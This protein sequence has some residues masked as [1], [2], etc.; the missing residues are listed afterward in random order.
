[1]SR[2]ADNTGND[3]DLSLNPD[4]DTI[5]ERILIDNQVSWQ[6]A[7][8]LYQLDSAAQRGEWHRQLWWM[9]YA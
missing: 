4:M 5:S 3:V 6:V 9:L 1:M 2:K 7:V 8:S